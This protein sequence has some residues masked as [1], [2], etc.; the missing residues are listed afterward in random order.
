MTKQTLKY[1]ALSMACLGLTLSASMSI[2]Q[3]RLTGPR[4][5]VMSHT[6]PGTRQLAG[7]SSGW[8]PH[9]PGTP[10]VIDFGTLDFPDASDSAAYTVNDLRQYAGGYGP[11]LEVNFA[12][13]GFILAENSFKIINYPGAVQ[14]T[15]AALNNTG[16]IVGIWQDTVGINHGFQLIKGTYSSID[17][18]GSLDTVVN[19]LSNSGEI[20]GVYDAPGSPGNGFMLVGGAYTT[21]DYP[22]AV[23]TYPDD[24]N[25]AGEIV[26]A[27]VDSSGN[28]HGFTW[29]SGVFAT[30]D[31][32][33]SPYTF[34][35]GINDSAV[36]VGAY[37]D[38]N[39]F[40]DGFEHGFASQGGEFLSIDVPFVGA[41]ATWTSGINNSGRITGQYIDTAGRV[42]GY[43]A[44]IKP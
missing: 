31:Y 11:D 10:T 9:I 2:A 15:A 39:I 3:G 8:Q 30:V 24:V 22:G 13:S 35:F 17:Y 28:Y 16:E 23:F 34:V 6:A 1:L 32:P 7:I 44:R 40:Y 37:G 18:P 29:V 41:G 43:T 4:G 14:T 25:A 26:G 5:R 21:I 38:G 36:L 42:Y 27:W 20:V 33:G 12:N 19:G